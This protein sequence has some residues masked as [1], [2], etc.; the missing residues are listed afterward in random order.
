MLIAFERR[1][2]Q[3]IAQFRA[4]DSSGWRFFVPSVALAEW[5]V[6]ATAVRDPSKRA[7]ATR[8]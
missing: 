2:P 8:F 1:D 3:V 5:L 6:G 4:W 7:K